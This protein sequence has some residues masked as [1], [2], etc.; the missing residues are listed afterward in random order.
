MSETTAPTLAD[1]LTHTKARTGADG[2]LEADL[3][4]VE[5]VDATTV[6]LTVTRPSDEHLTWKFDKPAVWSEESSFV[7]LVEDLGYSAETIEQLPGASLRIR[8]VTPPHTAPQDMTNTW[9]VAVP[10]SE[11]VDSGPETPGELAMLFGAT[12]LSVGL[13]IAIA[14]ALATVMVGPT[15]EAIALWVGFIGWL[16]STPLF[17]A[18][19]LVEGVT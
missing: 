4:A 15:I 3:V 11:A 18:R 16:L 10:D 1:E 13:V 12:Y 8:P 14:I 7:R 19:M 6:G 9:E 2:W 5:P 17:L